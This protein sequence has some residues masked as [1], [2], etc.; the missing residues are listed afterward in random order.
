MTGDLTGGCVCGEV[1]FRVKP[2][3]RLNPYACH[4][5][6]CQKRTGSAFAVQMTVMEKDFTVEGELTTGLY[7]QPSGTI[8]E[9][10]G[11]A[12]CLSR[13]YAKNNERAGLINL[14]IGNIDDGHKIT[15]VFHLWTS[16]KHDWVVIDSNVTALAT[17]PEDS[18]GW[19]K[20][21]MPG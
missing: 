11:C 5:K 19:I 4:C 3:M 7:Q 14:R 15:P 12:K 2:G 6:D 17:Q 20:L 1:R 18:K 13:V 8:S 21:L 16:S 9:I 10:Y